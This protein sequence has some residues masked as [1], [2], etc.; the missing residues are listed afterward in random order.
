MQFK[1]ISFNIRCCDDPNGHSIKE[2]APRLKKIL[3][4][5]KADIIGLQECRPKWL[6]HLKK[7]YRKEYLIFHK[8]RGDKESTPVLISKKRFKVVRKGYFWFSDTPHKKSVGWD[9]K[10][11]VPRICMWVILEDRKSGKQIHF[12]NTHLGFGKEGQRKGVE[13]IY[14]HT[15]KFLQQP[16]I[17]TGDFN[18]TPAAPAYAQMTKYF[19]DVN[20]ATVNNMRNTYH[21]YKTELIGQQIDYCFVGENIVPVDYKL[22]DTQFNGKFASDHYGIMAEVSVREK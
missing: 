3:Q 19:T 8:Y 6:K 14:R 17:I 13:L 12:M 4:E 9:E 1:I 2:R 18:I 16:V 7:D 15:R 21:G 10:Y 20:A 5:Q 22:L 11:H